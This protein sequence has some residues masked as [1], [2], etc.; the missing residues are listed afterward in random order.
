MSQPS[1]NAQSI[2]VTELLNLG[3][4]PE[5]ILGALDV[6]RREV[7]G[8]L[9]GHKRHEDVINLTEMIRSLSFVINEISTSTGKEVDD[10]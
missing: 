4:N 3:A 6:H 7:I 9:H 10:E 5:H 1:L 2:L 8:W